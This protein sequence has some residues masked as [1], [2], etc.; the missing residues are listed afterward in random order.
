V[1][2]RKKPVTDI[3]KVKAGDTYQPPAGEPVKVGK[4]V[5][6]AKDAKVGDIFEGP[7]GERVLVTKVGTPTQAETDLANKALR[8]TSKKEK[9][10]ILAGKPAKAAKRK[11]R[12]KPEGKEEKAGGE[13]PKRRRSTRQK[14]VEDKGWR[15]PKRT[16]SEG[17]RKSRRNR[18][19]KEPRKYSGI[20]P[21][22]KSRAKDKPEETEEGQFREIKP[23]R[24]E[25]KPAPKRGSPH[26]YTMCPLCGWWHI[27]DYTL[28]EGRK[29]TEDVGGELRFQIRLDGNKG[30][31]EEERPS[32]RHRRTLQG[33][34]RGVGTVTI[35]DLQSVDD[36]PQDLI[37][38]IL[39]QLNYVYIV[40]SAKKGTRLALA[41]QYG[42]GRAKAPRAKASRTRARKAAAQTVEEP[43]EESEEQVVEP[44]TSL[45]TREV[46]LA[47]YE[48]LVEKDPVGWIVYSST[49]AEAVLAYARKLQSLNVPDEKWPMPP[50]S[51]G[52]DI[53]NGRVLIEYNRLVDFLNT[54]Y[55]GF[56]GSARIRRVLR[57][58]QDEL[59]LQDKPTLALMVELLEQLVA[60]GPEA[61]VDM[62]KTHP[63][64]LLEEL[65]ALR[66]DVA[67]SRA[68]LKRVT[69]ELRKGP[70]SGLEIR[71]VN[72]LQTLRTDVNRGLAII[73]RLA[74][75]GISEAEITEYFQATSEML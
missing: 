37:D 40:L 36:L 6:V 32:V 27:E 17:E 61:S 4:I 73:A 50:Q 23:K 70:K 11:H 44:S 35:D 46:Q 74:D 51:A 2:T 33:F 41:R 14:L 55:E 72:L 15:P 63:A 34:G 58:M 24:R 22:R 8:T 9:E 75:A 39:A 19:E 43:S 64:N 54:W 53:V 29:R 20:V 62:A 10:R 56:S 7:D 47:D 49:V 12:K 71:R 59:G 57:R 26:Y 68:D 3:S 42:P 60:L 67:D 31:K 18:K 5:K 28:K 21:P 45:A 66:A 65:R 16:V 52:G 38:A 30:A 48:T 69:D 1:A 13:E 25:G